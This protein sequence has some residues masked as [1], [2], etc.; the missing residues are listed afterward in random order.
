MYVAVDENGA[1]YAPFFFLSSGAGAPDAVAELA[2]WPG[3]SLPCT[4]CAPGATLTGTPFTTHAVA[5]LTLDPEGEAYVV[6]NNTNA[7]SI[8]SRASVSGSSASNVTPARADHQHG[9]GPGYN[10]L[11]LW[12]GPLGMSP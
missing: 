3:T 1:L 11:G 12:V 5:G 2:I 7:V 9:F 6:N 8:F 10:L 4:N